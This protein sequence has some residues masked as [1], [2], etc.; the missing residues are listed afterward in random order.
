VTILAALQRVLDQPFVRDVVIVDDASTDGT[1][2]QLRLV[3]D[4]RVTVLTHPVNRGKGASVRTAVPHTLGPYVAIQDAD[5]EYDPAELAR[6]IEP[7]DADQ[8]DVVYGS[9]FLSGDAR[10][11]LYF[12]HSIGNRLLT[13]ASN[14]AT[15]INLSDMET[16]Y[17]VFRKEVLDQIT[18]QED[19]FGFEPEITAKIAI[20]KWRI[21][22]VG[23]SYQG[24]TYDQGKKISWRDGVEAGRCVV[25]YNVSERVRLGR[26][27]RL[28]ARPEATELGASLESLE[29]ADNYYDWIV[30]LIA[31]TLRGH[32]LEVGAGTGTVTSLLAKAGFPVTCIEPDAEIGGRLAERFRGCGDVTVFRGSCADFAG[33]RPGHLDSAVLVNVLEHIEDDKGELA[34]LTTLLGPDSPV[35]LWVPAF[36]FLYS[37]YDRE[38]GHFRRYSRPGI[39]AVCEAAGLTV[40]SSRYVNAPGA[41]AWGVTAKA[42]RMRPASG[43]LTGI[44]DRAFVPSIR[45]LES[46]TRVP[47]GQSILVTALTPA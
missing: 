15:N 3:D 2:D 23:I 9:R 4:P 42:L 5:L 6:L 40:T 30:S 33:G 31:P 28:H 44:Y 27:R 8:A 20:A 29:G 7:L 10:R 12:W 22:E 36:D 19:R 39:A 34:R 24:R 45:A 18:I 14:M 38:V 17:K 35:V 46:R 47:F 16:G 21:S 43:G 41:V 1:A 25:H 13:M 26:K 11:V 32:V 37:R